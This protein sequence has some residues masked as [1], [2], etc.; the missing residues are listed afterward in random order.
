MI[1]DR[2]E[3]IGPKNWAAFQEAALASGFQI[4]ATRVGPGPLQIETIDAECQ[5]LS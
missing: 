4:Y 2:A 3:S 5:V 1:A